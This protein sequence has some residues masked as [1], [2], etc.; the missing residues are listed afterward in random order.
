MRAPTAMPQRSPAFTAEFPHPSPCPPRR[1]RGLLVPFLA[2]SLAAC[3]GSAAPSAPASSAAPASPSAA[4]SKPAAASASVKPAASGAASAKPAASGSA[5]AKPAASLAAFAP[6]NPSAP[7]D[8]MIVS[9]SQLTSTPNEAALAAG[10]FAKHNLNL[11][12]RYIPQGATGMQVL[13]SG[14][15]NVAELGGAEMVAAAAGGADIV[16]I[17]NLEPVYPFKFEVTKDIQ[18]PADLKGKKVGITTVG[19]VDDTSIRAALP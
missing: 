19:S 16:I 12:M 11:D 17:A 2:L 6:Y 8:K 5:A 3:G 13:L 18:K 7:G 15:T 1:A 10:I 9:H 4:A 14:D